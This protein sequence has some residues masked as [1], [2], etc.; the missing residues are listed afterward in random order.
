MKKEE[1]KFKCPSCGS[2]KHEIIERCL[3][4]GVESVDRIDRTS[5]FTSDAKKQLIEM[6]EMFIIKNDENAMVIKD[7]QIKRGAQLLADFYMEL[8]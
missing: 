8:L 1:E 7:G 6:A 4:C 5:Y 2:K 3:N